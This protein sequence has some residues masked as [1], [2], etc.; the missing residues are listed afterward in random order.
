MKLVI[1]L[2]TNIGDRLQNLED[3]LTALE[4]LPNTEILKKSKHYITN[5]NARSAHAHL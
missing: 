3:A 4:L 2:G 5:P 1:G